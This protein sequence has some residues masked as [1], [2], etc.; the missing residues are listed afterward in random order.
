MRTLVL[1]LRWGLGLRLG[2]RSRLGGSDS[3]SVAWSRYKP[4]F[5]VQVQAQLDSACSLDLSVQDR[6]LVEGRLRV[7]LMECSR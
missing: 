7:T 4:F 3:G 2:S 1:V 5:P 6:R